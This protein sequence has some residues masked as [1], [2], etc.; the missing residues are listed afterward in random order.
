MT[1]VALRLDGLPYSNQPKVKDPGVAV[2]FVMKDRPIVLACDKWNR[3][4]CN[5]WAIA[6]HVEALRGQERWGIGT[7]EQA[8]T[9]YMA[10]PAP[11]DLKPWWEVLGI[12][13]E[14]GH[15][16]VRQAYRDLAVKNHPDNGGSHEGMVEV[17]QAWENAQLA[18][19]WK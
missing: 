10:L 1:N 8:F 9:G 11:M 2:Y 19:G 13:E 18:R 6:K 14:D 16:R 5:L 12:K 7:V 3:V 15:L 4:E 17:N